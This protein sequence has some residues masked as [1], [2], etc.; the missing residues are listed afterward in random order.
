MK[1]NH[2]AAIPTHPRCG[3]GCRAIL[4]LSLL[5]LPTLV[6]AAPLGRLFLTPERR[7]ALERQRQLNIQEKT[8][9]TIEVSNIHVNGMVRRSGG[10]TTVWVNGR[11]QLEGQVVTG[12]EVSPSPKQLEQVEIR[13]GEERA[14]ELRVGET[15]NRSTQEL[16]DG[17]KSGQLQVHSG[18]EAGRPER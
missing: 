4:L 7:V 8:Q 11:P 9:E 3:R 16:S 2:L 15:L 1:F 17:L 10:K 18:N 6:Q 5:L 12:V 13:V 14:A